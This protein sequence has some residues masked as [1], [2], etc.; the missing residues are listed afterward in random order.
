[1]ITM[2]VMMSLL[3]A[4]CSTFLLLQ[5]GMLDHAWS[6]GGTASVEVYDE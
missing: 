5:W 6:F 3:V 2:F 4:D 1:M